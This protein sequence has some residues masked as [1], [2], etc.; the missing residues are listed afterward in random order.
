M[1]AELAEFLAQRGRKVSLIEES[2]KFAVELPLVRRW[3]VLEEL[4]QLSVVMINHTR[5]LR[6]SGRQLL[7]ECQG[8]EVE[9]EADTIILASGARGDLD[10]AE[11]IRRM[12]YETHVAGDCAGVGYLEGAMRSAHQVATAV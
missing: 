9:I 3:R 2:G 4:K 8:N 6:V 1:G 7:I 11:R 12:G 5:L 10:L